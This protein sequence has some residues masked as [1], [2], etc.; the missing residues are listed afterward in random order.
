MIWCLGTFYMNDHI[1]VVR[2]MYFIRRKEVPT[3]Q[4]AGKRLLSR[5]LWPDFHS[6]LEACDLKF[7]CKQMVQCQHDNF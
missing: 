6:L 2:E 1:K 3:I 4:E 5:I 7:E